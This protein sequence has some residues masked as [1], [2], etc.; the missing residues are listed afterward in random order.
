MGSLHRDGA[1]VSSSGYV[2]G[3]YVCQYMHIPFLWSDRL[4][5][6]RYGEFGYQQL[7]GSGLGGLQGERVSFV[8][9]NM[10]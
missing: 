6:G 7:G 2:I 3:I 9:F 1:A 10:K 8:L 4:M 5:P